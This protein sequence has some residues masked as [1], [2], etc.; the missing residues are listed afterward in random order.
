L[1]LALPQI[2]Q[3][4]LALE[5]E[6]FVLRGKFHPAARDM[7]WCDRRLLARIHRL[8]LNRLRAEIE[9]VSIAHFQR[10]LMAWQ[11]VAIEHRAEGPG[12][13]AAVIAMLDGYELPAAAWE[14]E[15]LAARVRHYSPEWLDH[16]CLTG[17][18]G[19]GR[20]SP[21]AQAAAP[22]P[23]LRSTPLSLFAR[24]HL[25]HWMEL[26][27]PP[28]AGEFSCEQERIL[29]ALRRRGALFFDEIAAHTRFLRTRLEDALAQLAARGWVTSD[30]FEGLRVLLL[31]SDKRTPF[32]DLDRKRRHP[33]VSGIES[34]GR[35]WLLRTPQTGNGPPPDNV[36]QLELQPRE[37]AVEAFAR[38]LLRRYGI[39]FRRLL[40]RETLQASWFELGRFYRRLEARGE[41]RG[42]Y[43][44]SAV[45][46]E[47]FALPEAVDLLRSVR[48]APP[49]AE[50][51][52]LS[53]ADPLNLVGILT[54]GARIASIRASR[55]LFRDGLPIA[56]LQ[57]GQIIRLH[58]DAQSAAR[59]IER[60]LTVGTLPPSLRPYY[61]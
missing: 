61:A 51:I 47:Q 54:P 41:I 8:T 39:V 16:L 55:I 36:P 38:L 60:A 11:R 24:E 56:A 13:A 27:P 33:V 10:F 57:G 26:S 59:E 49:A 35:W 44:I 12:G 29:D 1:A 19:W 37:Q 45:S 50:L 52:A 42:G 25:R 43:F 2:Q 22:F 31:P 4:L 32:G 6:G 46:G 21:P 53:A 14:P 30:S 7:E 5:A 17:R 18:L 58:N 20:L 23:S 40:E 3:A 9:P 34:A 48:K 28:C 15:V